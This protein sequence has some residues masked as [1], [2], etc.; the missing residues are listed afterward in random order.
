MHW[1][2]FVSVVAM[3][4]AAATAASG[5]TLYVNAA[6]GNDATPRASNSAAS[7]W[8]TLGR[9][10][11]GSTSR[12]RPD[13]AE[14]AQ[15]GDVVVVA[16]GTYDQAAQGKARNQPLYNPVNNGTAE[17]PITFR[18]EGRVELRS[19]TYE[20]PV[21]GT[22]QRSFI[23]WDGFY[24]DEQY[25]HYTPDT[26]PVVVWDS[27]H[28]T[29]QNLEISGTYAPYV[30]NHTGIRLEAADD[31]L[32]RNN[33]VYGFGITRGGRQ[34]RSRNSTCIQLYY[35]NR[36]VIEHNEIRECG[37]GVFVKDTRQGI[38]MEDITIRL[39]LIYDMGKGPGPS[40]SG[41]ILQSV[42]RARVYQ[43][44]IRDSDVGIEIEATDR[45]LERPVD[46]IVANNTLYELTDGA[47]R[48]RGA[49][50]NW[51]KIRIVNNLTDRSV[52]LWGEDVPAPGDVAFEHNNYAGVPGRRFAYLKNVEYSFGDWRKTFKN[53]GAKPAS[54]TS[55]PRFVDARARDLRPCQGEARPADGCRSASPV[56]E[57]GVDVLD[58]DGDGVETNPIPA[59]AY[60][61]GDEIVG[62][63][64]VQR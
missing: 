46:V 12:E 2:R 33:L 7:P 31:V 8:K 63:V 25:V 19:S 38:T 52:V 39:N 47:F 22:F 45:P 50:P 26:G 29:V 20:G 3:L 32:V 36:I 15:P 21:I 6:T 27:N 49:V 37:S 43:N 40:A 57:L 1:T 55:D 4:C 53:D 44:V 16:A 13:R 51:E 24:I 64:P 62:R 14:A 60:L 34:E 58:L 17:E 35:S 18:A 41:I 5:A 42:T 61:T 11:W 28:V 30:D 10:A 48:L 59:G 56:L 54:T 23:V 9:A